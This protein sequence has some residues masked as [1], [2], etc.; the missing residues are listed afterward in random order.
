M[1]AL[2][3]IFKMYL[4][5]FPLDVMLSSKYWRE[6]NDETIQDQLCE[7]SVCETKRIKTLGR[8]R[9]RCSGIMTVYSVQFGV[10]RVRSISGAIHSQIL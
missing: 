9:L 3:G 4:S 7:L 8:L 10:V 1:I 5:S 6:G 2:F